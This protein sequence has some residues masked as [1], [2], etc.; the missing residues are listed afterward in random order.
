MN[1]NFLFDWC[2]FGFVFKIFRNSKFC[3][4]YLSIDLQILWF[5]LWIT[6]FKKEKGL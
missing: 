5:N 2:D 6:L 4:Y 3:D 1:I